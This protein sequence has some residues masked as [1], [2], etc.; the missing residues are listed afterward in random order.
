MSPEA[1]RRQIMESA[2]ELMVSTGNSGCTLE[3]VAQAA[4]ISKPLIYKYFPRREDLI[5]EMLSRELAELN[6]RGLDSIDTEVPF[7]KIV[8]STVARSL[9]YYHDRGPILRLLSTDPAITTLKRK[10]NRTSWSSAF[11]FLVR[12]S[13]EHYGVPESVAVI[14]SIMILNAPIYSMA[15]LRRRDVDIDEAIEV[16]SEFIIGGWRALEARFGDPD[17]R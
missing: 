5:E 10:P 7:E 3:Q 12:R 16:W 17:A 4:G 14:T 8:R 2:A 13:V 11:Q 1:R 9:R 15:S 6:G